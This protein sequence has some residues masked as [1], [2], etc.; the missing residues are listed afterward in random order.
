MAD[1]KTPEELAA[2]VVADE[3][4]PDNWVEGS[5][6]PI[7]RSGVVDLSET[8]EHVDVQCVGC[9]NTF[10]FDIDSRTEGFTFVCTVCKT[11]TAWT[12]A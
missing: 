8:P 10:G 3:R 11:Q 5:A 7:E 9:N 4:N 12:R 2:E 6:E 1:D